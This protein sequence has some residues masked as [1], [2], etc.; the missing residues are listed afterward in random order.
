[1][2]LICKYNNISVYDNNCIADIDVR[3]KRFKLRS[4]SSDI[5]HQVFYW[6]KGQVFRVREH[7]G[8]FVTEKYMYI[9]L[10]K[11]SF[12]ETFIVNNKSA[13]YI[14]P[15]GFF[16]KVDGRP[17]SQNVLASSYKGRVQDVFDKGK[18]YV[19]KI[20]GFLNSDMHT[21]KRIIQYRKDLRVIRRHNL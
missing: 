16:D 15:N 17:I 2:N 10:Q 1:M 20:I 7:K 19:K 9:H 3:F 21:K 13:F 5:K 8:S 14:L 12:K 18:Y 6:E 4:D 11:R